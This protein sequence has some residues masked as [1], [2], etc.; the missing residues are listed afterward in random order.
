LK[1]DGVRAGSVWWGLLLRGVVMSV[2]LASSVVLAEDRLPVEIVA[3][4]GASYDAPENTVAAFRLAWEQ[5][6]DGSE[7]DLYLTKDGQIIAFHDKTTKRTAG[8]DLPV[9]QTDFAEL[10]KLDVG[11]FKDARFRNER[12]PTV[13]ELLATAPPGKKVYLEVKCGPEIVPAL[14]RELDRLGRPVAETPVISFGAEVIAEYK[15]LAPKRP[16]YFLHDPSKIAASALLALVRQM[17]ADGV[18]LRACPELDETYAR[19][20]REAGLRLD[21]W[22]VNDVAV[23]RRLV[24]LGVRGITTDRPAFL[25]EGLR[26]AEAR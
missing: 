5:G 24:G 10:R 3:H 1:S 13:E 2:A 9:A 4:R 25:R 17:R 19:T 16:A 14:L 11:S 22:T 6:A 26:G 15:R 18:D 20:V 21:V 7:C 23:A 12:P 8:V